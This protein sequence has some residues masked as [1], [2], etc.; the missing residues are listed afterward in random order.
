MA[1][2]RRAVEVFE[3]LVAADPDVYLP[4]LAKSLHNL[5]IDLAEA[6]RYEEA[7]AAA[8]RAVEVNRR[9]A[10]DSPSDYREEHA[11]S[12]MVLGRLQIEEARFAEAV[13]YLVEAAAVAEQPSGGGPPVIEVAAAL[14]R[15]AY[16]FDPDGVRER[17]REVTD[18]DVVEWLDSKTAG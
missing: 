2:S 4:D 7:V 1:A 17:M 3:R 5:A 15:L 16:E 13:P 18:Q 12:L 10:E 14:L 8:R 6:G 11:W 9:L